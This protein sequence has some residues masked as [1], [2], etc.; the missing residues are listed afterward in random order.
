MLPAQHERL[1][2]SALGVINQFWSYCI[3]TI[4][5]SRNT[6]IFLN[7]G[8]IFSMSTCLIHCSQHWQIIWAHKVF[9]NAFHSSCADVSETGKDRI[10]D[11]LHRNMPQITR[12][13]PHTNIKCCWIIH[14]MAQ[15][16]Q[17]RNHVRHVVTLIH[18]IHNLSLHSLPTNY[19]KLHLYYNSN[20]KCNSKL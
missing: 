4:K 7:K 3:W 15:L 17:E 14:Q 13:F 11:T 1:S 5:G 16:Q 12:E 2:G 6:R 18:N 8:M 20:K 9:T 10:A 19:I